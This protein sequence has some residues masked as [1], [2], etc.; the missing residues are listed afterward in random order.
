MT[1]AMPYTAPRGKYHSQV[2]AHLNPLTPQET[3]GGIHYYL[4]FADW[5]SKAQ[6]SE[7]LAQSHTCT[8]RSDRLPGFLACTLTTELLFTITS[9]FCCCFPCGSAGKVS[10]CNVEDLGLTPGLGRS[11]GEKKG[12]PLQYSGLDNSMNCIVHV[13]TKSLTCLSNF[14]F[15]FFT[16]F[17]GFFKLKY[18]WF[19][20]LW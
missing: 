8:K 17:K 20:M 7:S 16:F 19:T 9:F 12:Y 15:H 5:E 3:L 18:S 1:E 10:T 6:R 13:V 11:T 2:L 4:H 14:H